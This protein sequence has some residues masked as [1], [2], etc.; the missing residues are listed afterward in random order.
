MYV[1][2]SSYL[3]SP[4]TG[5]IL[6]ESHTFRKNY[7]EEEEGEKKNNKIQSKYD[8]LTMLSSVIVKSCEK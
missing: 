5:G 3:F 8:T 4:I 2:V 6:F 7:A 1:E